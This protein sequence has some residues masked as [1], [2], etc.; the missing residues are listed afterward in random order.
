MYFMFGTDEKL[1]C[2]RRKIASLPGVGAQCLNVPENLV[3]IYFVLAKK[4]IKLS[5][6]TS[7]KRKTLW[8]DLPN[9]IKRDLP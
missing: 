5:K 2:A 8:N 4:M 3:L 1:L 6:L 9:N 7:F